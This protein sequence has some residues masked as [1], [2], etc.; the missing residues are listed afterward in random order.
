MYKR[1]AELDDTIKLTTPEYGSIEALD[2]KLQL[3]G[4]RGSAMF[5]PIGFSRPDSTAFYPPKNDD[6]AI[7]YLDFSSHFERKKMW[8]T[9]KIRRAVVTYRLEATV[10]KSKGYITNGGEKLIIPNKLEITRKRNK[11]I[12]KII[13]QEHYQNVGGLSLIHI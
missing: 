13:D 2:L 4:G 5:Q 3:N 8:P 9:D 11:L 6:E 10:Q 12:E 7:E 1:Q